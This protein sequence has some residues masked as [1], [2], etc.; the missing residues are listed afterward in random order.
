MSARRSLRDRT[1]KLSMELLHLRTLCAT[2]PIEHNVLLITTEKRKTSDADLGCVKKPAANR[3]GVARQRHGGRANE[4]HS[5]R[6]DG[7]ARPTRLRSAPTLPLARLGS[8]ARGNQALA[9]LRRD[10]G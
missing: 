6:W 9:P 4:Q 7:K 5:R 8:I 2:A 3:P 10:G 1:T